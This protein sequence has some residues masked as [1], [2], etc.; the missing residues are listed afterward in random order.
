MTRPEKN[1]SF[2]LTAK[3][4][5]GNTDTHT[6]K[7]RTTRALTQTHILGV[8]HAHTYTNTDAIGHGNGAAALT[9]IICSSYRFPQLTLPLFFSPLSL[10]CS[11]CYSPT[12][13]LVD[14]NQ[15]ACINSERTTQFAGRLCVCERVCWA[16][17]TNRL[18]INRTHTKTNKVCV[19]ARCI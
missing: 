17:P 11:L 3:Y 1:L 7:A 5:T 4:A 12:P 10:F 8:G 19:Q 16:G 6:H 14:F 18:S 9:H 13:Q 2:D 15:T